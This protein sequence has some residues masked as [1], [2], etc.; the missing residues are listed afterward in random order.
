VLHR[1]GRSADIVPRGLD[2]V[3]FAILSGS[4][5]NKFTL[6]GKS[7]KDYQLTFEATDFGRRGN[8]QCKCLER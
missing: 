6:K 5:A 2:S 8:E 3:D 1:L 4:D 7:F